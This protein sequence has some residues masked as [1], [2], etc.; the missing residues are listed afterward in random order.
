MTDRRDAGRSGRHLH[1]QVGPVHGRPKPQRFSHRSFGV[2]GQVGRAFQA[3]V[4]VPP[5]RLFVDGVQDVGRG[6][7]VGDCQML[8]DCRDAVVRLPL[9]LFQ[10]FGIFVGLADRLLED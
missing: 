2:V 9:E 7:D 1:H 10:G 3:D 6:T 4:A 5:L 8:V